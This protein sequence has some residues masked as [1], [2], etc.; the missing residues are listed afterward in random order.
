[1]RFREEEKHRRT[2]LGLT[3]KSA[4]RIVA[5]VASG[6]ALA[7][8]GSLPSSVVGKVGIIASGDVFSGAT[9]AIYDL[10]RARASKEN[11]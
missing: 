6:G 5:L 7:V 3:G 1:V 11:F 2:G 10:G 4:K 8:A 9:N